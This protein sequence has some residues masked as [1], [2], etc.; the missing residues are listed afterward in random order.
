VEYVPPSKM[1][2]AV[3]AALSDPTVKNKHTIISRIVNGSKK[4]AAAAAD[5]AVA[6][7]N[8]LSNNIIA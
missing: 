2:Q 4:A 5:A 7:Q 3:I 1:T 6:D 8:Y